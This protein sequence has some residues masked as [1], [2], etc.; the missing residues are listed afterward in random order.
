M[1]SQAGGRVLGRGAV[2]VVE[3]AAVWSSEGHGIHT[4]IVGSLS[5]G[6]SLTTSPS[7]VHDA[8]GL[9]GKR[10]L[11]RPQWL[12]PF[13]MTCLYPKQNKAP[14]AQAMSKGG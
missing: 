6:L 7:I 5:R 9:C 2:Q 1:E 8:G 4:A 14:L 10:N 11:I 13:D 3:S 12:Q